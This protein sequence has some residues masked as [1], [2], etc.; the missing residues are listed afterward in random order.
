MYWISEPDR[1]QSDAINKGLYRATGE[2]VNWIN[3]DD[4][5]E[6]NALH[7]VAEAFESKE[8]QVVCGRSRLFRN[9][10]ET[11]SYSRGTD[12][13]SDNLA[14][15]IGWARIDQPET[16][17]RREVVKKIGL[18]NVN[19]HYVMDKA[20]WI[21]YLLFYGLDG[22]HIF[23]KVLVNFRLHKS[24]KTVSQSESFAQE[25]DILFL[26]LAQQYGLEQEAE[27]LSQLALTGGSDNYDW[28]FPQ[29]VDNSLIRKAIHYHLLH[30]ADEL[31]Y[32]HRREAAKLCL[33]CINLL[34]LHSSEQKLYQ[35]LHSRCRCWPV[36]LVKLLRA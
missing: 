10:G 33:S 5:Y 12:I 25:T 8:V 2:V 35:K 27:G 11:V 18:L 13:Y 15:T 16:F 34:L 20:W 30:R 32:Q 21:N 9:E 19:S 14:K 6:S 7:S 28:S 1:G 23:N 31:Y 36:S 22:I 26:A 4:Y 3:S 17:F 24:S 29:S